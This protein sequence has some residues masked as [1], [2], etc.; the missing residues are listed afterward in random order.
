MIR[1]VYNQ[2]GIQCEAKEYE[3]INIRIENAEAL[4]TMTNDLWQQVNGKEGSVIVS[5][6]FKELKLSKSAEMIV[7]PFS[8]DNNEKRIVSKLYRELSE[9]AV[10]ELFE[11][12]GHVNSEIIQ[13]LD[14]LLDRSQYNLISDLDVDI[15]GLLKLY[16]VKIADDGEDIVSKFISYIRALNEICGVIMVITLNLKQFFSEQ[17]L[18]QLYEFCRYQKVTIVNIGGGSGRVDIPYEKNYILDKDLCFIEF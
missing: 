17:Q 16:N 1:I 5:C 12:V 13:F 8:I 2:Y 10:N 15:Q 4:Y 18:L 11:E 14:L 7:N 6:D 9:M 3:S